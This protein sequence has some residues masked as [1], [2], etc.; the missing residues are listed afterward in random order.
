MSKSLIMIWSFSNPILPLL[1]M[2]APE[3]VEC[4]QFNP[5]NPNIV[6]GGCSNG[7]LVLWDLKEYMG[8][9]RGETSK[10]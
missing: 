5:L 3:D 1:L 9:L 7:Q 8:V 2:E 6:C 10:R 4:F